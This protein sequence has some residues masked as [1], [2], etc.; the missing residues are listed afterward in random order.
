MT[1]IQALTTEDLLTELSRRGALAPLH[2]AIGAL[3]DHLEREGALDGASPLTA[4]H[5]LL[6]RKHEAAITA[7]SGWPSTEKHWDEQLRTLGIRA[8]AAVT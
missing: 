7:R 8:A 1:G 5:L 2:C 6:L 4:Y 3:F